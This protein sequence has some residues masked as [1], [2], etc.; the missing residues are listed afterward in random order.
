M[1]AHCPLFA[2]GF[3]LPAPGFRCFVGVPRK[4]RNASDAGPSS[5]ICI[6]APTDGSRA[7][8]QRLIFLTS[9]FFN[10]E[11][12]ACQRSQVLVHMLGRRVHEA[13]FQRAVL[14]GAQVPYSVRTFRHW[15]AD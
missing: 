9:G 4:A 11:P 2:A 12:T 6:Y 7:G 1:Y 10:N 8:R 14:F 5:N 3:R 13:P 15:R